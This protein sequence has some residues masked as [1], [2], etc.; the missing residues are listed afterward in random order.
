MEV[1][2]VT[3]GTVGAGHLVR[4]VALSRALARRGASLRMLGPPL[5]FPIAHDVGYESIAVEKA[6]LGDASRVAESALAK[7]LVALS[8]DVVVVDLFWAVA[9]EIVPLLHAEAWLLVRAAPDVWLEGPSGMP[10]RP[11]RWARVLGIEPIA[12]RGAREQ[13]APIVVASPDEVVPRDEVRCRFA[14]S[15]DDPLELVLHAGNP[16]ELAALRD[17]ASPAARVLDLR[18]AAAPFPAAPWLPA[19]DRI[20]AAAGYNT[21]WESKLLGHHGRTHFVPFARPIDDQARRIRECEHVRITENG[22]DT[23]ATMLVG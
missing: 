2:Y 9:Q 4:G 19:A 7:R 12:A 22:A 3:G 17:L 18:N 10:F 5:D 11:E 20:V 14:V 6:L 13:I 21:F 23:L 1:V 16:G 15:A 8:P